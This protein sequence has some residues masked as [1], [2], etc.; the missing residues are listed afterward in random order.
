MHIKKKI[1]T[2]L[3]LP[4]VLMRFT[5]SRLKRVPSNVKVVDYLPQIDVLG[6]IIYIILLLVSVSL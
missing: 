3:F 2:T 6:K 1:L 4:Q 5:A